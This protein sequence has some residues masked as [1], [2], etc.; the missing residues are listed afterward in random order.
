ML[1]TISIILPARNS[2]DYLNRCVDSVIAQQF[3]GWELLVINDGSSDNTRDIADSYCKNDPRIRLFDSTGSGVSAARNLGL[4][5]SVG[6]YVTF[7]DSDDRL[8][9]GFLS[10]LIGMCEKENADIAQCSFCYSYPDGT[11]LRDK[12]A[13]SAVFDGHE[14]IMNAYFSGMIGKVNLA[15]WGK[16]YRRDLVKDI[17]FDET[18]KIQED[19]FFTFQCCMKASKIACSN[20]ARYYYS[21][22]PKSV[23]NK[24]F[25]GSKMQY[26]T[27][28]DRELESCSENQM[29]CGKIKIRK[30]ITALDLT[31]MIVREKS[32]G[33]YLP[34]L[35]ETALETHKEIGGAVKISFK[36]KM[37]IFI[38]K[39][40]PKIYY[41][42][43]KI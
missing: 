33:E 28:L 43:L 29:L 2:A 16:L 38:L 20:A 37:K 42:L 40:F 36:N 5:N 25:D 41:G 35:R 18:L 15:C 17:R 24:P 21:Q 34:K 39:H 32:G 26:F 19:A 23:M 1:P 22:N 6:S 12:E 3:T 10:D 11:E 8:A 7:L 30:M 4:E 14:E 9:P 27:V 31:A 13:V